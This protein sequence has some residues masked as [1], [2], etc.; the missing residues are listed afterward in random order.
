MLTNQDALLK[1]LREAGAR[2]VSGAFDRFLE[3]EINIT[4][5][6]REM[7][8]DSQN[9]LREFLSSE[10][11][12][13]ST[14]PRVLSIEDSD[15][16]GGSFA[17]H[18][19]N[20][21]LDDIDV[22]LPLDGHDLVYSEWG[23]RLPY[24]VVSD[25]V[26]AANPLLTSR[27]MIAPHISSTKLIEEFAAV[28]RRHYPEE[29]D[30]FPNG[31]AVSIRMKQG[32]TESGKGLGYDVVP[33]FRLKPDNSLELPFYVMPN[34]SGGWLRTNPRYDKDISEGLQEK[35]G[36]TFRKAV[37]LV[38]YWNTSQL[39][40]VLSSYYIEL[41]ISHAF[42]DENKKGTFIKS[43]PLAAATGFWALNRAVGRGNQSPWITGAPAVEPGELNAFHKLLVTNAH[44]ISLEAWNQERVGQEAAAIKTWQKL[45]GPSFE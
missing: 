43:V 33:C 28:L 17:R 29:T 3:K 15:F 40:G 1:L 34:G 25:G 2:T 24:T 5:G 16:L 23:A 7:A 12:R 8:S 11:D 19:K 22:Y 14:F 4:S 42:L 36:K 26:L 35:N 32:E 21:P 41:G 10:T 20:W 9:H 38:K 31:E 39:D 44:T 37:K 18:V 30:V 6:I 13:D 27:W 45:F